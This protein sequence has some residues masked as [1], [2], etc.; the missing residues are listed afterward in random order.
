MVYFTKTN[1]HLS[2]LE[3]MRMTPGLYADLVQIWKEQNAPKK[4]E[5]NFDD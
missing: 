4:P 1:L 5:D 3:L 2:V